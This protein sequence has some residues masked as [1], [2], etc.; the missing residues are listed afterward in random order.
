M[1][2][3]CHWHTLTC[4]TDTAVTVQLNKLCKTALNC[5]VSDVHE[6]ALLAEFL[7]LAFYS[8]AVADFFW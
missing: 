2:T 5:V 7:Y 4:A 3:W 1:W 6:N 8:H